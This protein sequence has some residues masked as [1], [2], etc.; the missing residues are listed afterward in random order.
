MNVSDLPALNATL[1][2]VAGC[3]LAAGYACIRRGLRNAHRACMIAA[4][5]ASALF[6]ASYVVY[7]ANAGSKPFPGT[8][9]ARSIYFAILSTHV[10]LAA[11]ILP[12]AI[13][14]LAR[15][16]GGRFDRH[17]RIARWTLPLWLYVSATGVV[18][19]WMLYRMS[20]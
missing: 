11:A 17:V 20:W 14:T 2:G 7:H 9:L 4:F 18:I 16:L 3:F 12:M 15:A 10:V 13:V 5:S 6:L 8:G 19:Y 1:N